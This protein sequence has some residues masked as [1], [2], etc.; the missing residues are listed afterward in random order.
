MLGWNPGT[1]QELFT[2]EEMIAQFSLERVG[3]SGSKFDP[4]KTKWF[5]QQYLR[6][7]S[8]EELASLVK[9]LLSNYNYQVQDYKLAKICTLMVERASFIKDII[10]EG[11]YFF[12][13]PSEYNED[14]VAK[15]WKP[16]SAS[17]MQA[18]RELFATE[19][20]FMEV[21]LEA[22]FKSYLESKALQFGALGPVIRIV[23]TG[24]MTGPSVFALAEIIGKEE[25][26]KRI[27]AA[28]TKLG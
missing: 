21:K 22:I 25:T 2:R 16:D 19:N 3:K 12:E 13:A 20:E 18:I 26:L 4:D 10:E 24:A 15:K 5:N 27:D 17:H 6:A 23:L 14:A 8:G 7:K 1:P 9:P 11:K 28:L